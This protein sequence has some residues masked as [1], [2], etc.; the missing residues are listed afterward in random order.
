[1]NCLYLT[2][3]PIQSAVNRKKRNQI[4]IWFDHLSLKELFLS[5]VAATMFALTVTVF[6]EQSCQELQSS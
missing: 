6:S 2:F 4:N 3:I 5:F 1:M